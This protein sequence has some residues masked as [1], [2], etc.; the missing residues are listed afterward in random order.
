[1]FVDWTP[2]SDAMEDICGVCNSDASTCEIIDQVYKETGKGHQKNLTVP[3]GSIQIMV[4]ETK[5]SK[6]F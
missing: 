5:P 1:M 4:E 3:A 2:D 6:N